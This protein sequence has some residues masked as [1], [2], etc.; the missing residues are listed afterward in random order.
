[1][2]GNEDLRGSDS[3]AWCAVCGIKFLSNTSGTN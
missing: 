3:L 1:M 2:D